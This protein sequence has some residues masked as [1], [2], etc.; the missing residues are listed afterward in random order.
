M[1]ELSI[2]TTLY[3]S[4]PF[5]KDFH[6]RATA[7]AAAVSE[8]YEIVF[9]ND[10]S[11]DNSA[12]V[13]KQITKTDSHVRVVELSRNFGHHVAAF[14][15]IEA[16]RGE[17][18]FLIDSDLEES[19]E[20]LELFTQVMEE[21]NAD[22]VYGFQSERIGI[23]GGLFY[24]VFNAI[25]DTRIPANACTVRLMRRSYVDALTQVRDRKMFMAGMFM[26]AGFHQ[27]GVPVS[28]ARRR[29]SKSTYDMIRQLG[30]FIDA[31]TSFSSKPLYAA[32]FAGAAF[33]A[34]SSLI[35]LML[36]AR[37][38]LYPETV[39]AGFTT[40]L[41]SIIFMGGLIIFFLGVIGIYISKIFAEAKDRP[42]YLTR[43]ENPSTNDPE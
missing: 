1:L 37:K 13:A 15:G 5:I 36:V 39:L 30:L 34:G 17:R 23:L 14:A 42:L 11:P 16:A 19:P 10:G 21:N 2:V 32:F 4:A 26:W 28:K 35:G 7:S 24:K 3:R 25:S 38:L 40:L 9:V 33:A 43:P 20:W 31:V 29:E 12:A 22:V 6:A 8:S 18:V 41:V 27:I